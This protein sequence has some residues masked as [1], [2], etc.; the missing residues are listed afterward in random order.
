[1]TRRSRGL[2]QMC[3]NASDLP[4]GYT[5]VLAL[6]SLRVPSQLH[7]VVVENPRHIGQPRAD[8][9][10]SAGVRC[11]GGSVMRLSVADR[12]W[13]KVD[14]S[15]GPDGCWLWIGGVTPEG[16]G[17]FRLPDRHVPA[18]K[19]AYELSAGPLPAGVLVCHK[20]DIAYPLG[21]LTYRR[22]VNLSHLWE[23][24]NQ[25]NT[26]DRHAKGRDARGI[27]QG[28]HTRPETRARGERNGHA[29][30]SDGEVREIRRRR[31]GGE[32]LISIA[33]NLGI[34]TAEV[35]KVALRQA[36]AHVE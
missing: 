24:T 29:K 6:E 16:Y 21:D 12:F 18:H 36:W 3:Y 11:G 31:A 8:W 26:A 15:A 23:G 28:T 34:S 22:C 17:S 33:R 14:K 19:Y 30:L 7:I 20:C 2:T 25:E 4:V 5:G 1:V 32:L 9:Q 10:V 13:S 35:S 27:R